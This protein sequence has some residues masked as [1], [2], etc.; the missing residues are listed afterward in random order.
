MGGIPDL[1]FV[2]DTN[3]EDIA[4][5]EAQRLGIP[6]AA[7]VDTN[8]N[9]DGITFTVPG[10][11]DAGRAIALYTDLV[12]KAALDGI[13]RAQ[14]E[15]GIDI[16][17]QAKPVMQEE[18]PAERE[19]EF[20]QLPGPRGA[21]DD[22][23]KLPGVSPDVEKQLQDL[24]IFHY[25]QVAGLGKKDAHHLGETVGLPGRVEGWIAQAKAVTAE[26]E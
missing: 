16:G 4:I 23:K 1:I 7:I 24:G 17:A 15:L 12:A 26:A 5:K 14:G 19:W 2:I 18:L 11:D 25:W 9:P 3:K 8:C 21:P 10:N 6:V 20:E 13:S 22:L